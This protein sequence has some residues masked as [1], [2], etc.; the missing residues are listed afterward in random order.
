MLFLK[1]R[2]NFILISSNTLTHE[3]EH[4]SDQEMLLLVVPMHYGHLAQ[5]LFPSEQWSYLDFHYT[6]IFVQ[7][8]F[9]PTLL[10]RLCEYVLNSLPTVGQYKSKFMLFKKL[11]T[12]HALKRTCA[13]TILECIKTVSAAITF[14]PSHSWHTETLSFITAVLIK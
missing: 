1:S 4:V 11:L 7:K 5:E 12:D 2:N 3:S 8:W 10:T 6:Q 14:S 9:D 13:T